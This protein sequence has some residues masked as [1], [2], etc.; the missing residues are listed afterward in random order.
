M[1][2]DIKRMIDESLS[3][4][5][6]LFIYFCSTK[7]MKDY[8]FYREQ[9]GGIATRASV[10]TLINNGYLE[11][12]D[13][14]NEQIT[15]SNLTL[16]NKARF[17]VADMPTLQAKEATIASNKLDWMEEWYSFFP[18]G[19][20]SGGYPVRSGLTGCRTK[21][22]KFLKKNKFNKDT[23][24][25]ATKLYIKEME[26]VNYS[27]MSLAHYFIEKD[28]KSILEAYCEQVLDKQESGE[29]INIDLNRGYTDSFNT[30]LN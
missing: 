6:C 13:P 19:V 12:V 27:F 10:L 22:F 28:G 18:K 24:L 26:K 3:V 8:N 23:I 14:T 15:F 25:L 5:D 21:M 11:F 9:F 17:L 16:T 2:I 1:I 20:K 7:N 4:N 29:D 30:S